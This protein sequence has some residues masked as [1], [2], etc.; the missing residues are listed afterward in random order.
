MIMRLPD[1]ILFIISRLNSRGFKGF[2]VGGCVRDALRGIEPN[3]YDVATDAA[4]GDVLEAF[5]DCKTVETG[6]KHGT[7]TV[8][9]GGRNVEVT[10]FRIDG[11]YRD[12]RHP[13]EVRFTK[14][15]NEDLSRRDFTVNAMAFSPEIGLVDLFDGER[16]LNE[17]IIKCVGNPDERFSEDGLRI[18][19]A[20]RFSS[21]LDFEIE[22][23][24]A[25]SIYKN[26]LLLQNISAERIYAELVKLLLGAGV[27]R[28]IKEFYDV[29]YVFAPEFEAVV[30][31]G[32]LCHTAQTID[33]LPSEKLPRLAAFLH[34]VG[35]GH[36]GDECERI[37]GVLMN[38]L[39]TDNATRKNIQTLVRLCGEELRTDAA[40][41][42]RLISKT[43]V[44]TAKDLIKLKCSCLSALSDSEKE[45]SEALKAGEMID[46]LVSGGECLSMKDLAVSGADLIAAGMEEG[47]RLGAVLK[48]LYDGV[49]DG[50]L[51][52]DRDALIAEAVKQAAQKP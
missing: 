3:D 29:F 26:R 34:C 36:G 4:P 23:E 18:L 11:E 42:R 47:E 7:V 14:E 28:V 27:G 9:S 50:K 25:H 24:T 16:H 12:N 45:L 52:N 19:R 15:L 31:R 5:D 33:S 2:A 39:K 8:V 35:A 51:Q 41:L 40:F 20:L 37:C 46:R 22:R 49:L 17:R 44:G 48:L 6:L 10:S 1:E 30:K 21:A 13:S 38:R 32:L 43:S